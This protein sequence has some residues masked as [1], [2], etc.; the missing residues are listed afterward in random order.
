MKKFVMLIDKHYFIEKKMKNLLMNSILLGYRILCFFFN[1][2]FIMELII[3]ERLLR[4]ETRQPE[5]ENHN[6]TFRPQGFIS[7]NNTQ[8]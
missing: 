4:L 7:E 1:I 3:K 6:K 8:R 2:L 5:F